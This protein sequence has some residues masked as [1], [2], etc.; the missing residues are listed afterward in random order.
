MILM[1]S[2]KNIM[3]ANVYIWGTNKFHYIVDKERG[4]ADLSTCDNTLTY[5][6]YPKRPRIV[7]F[8]CTPSKQDGNI[9]W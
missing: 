5:F 6:Q 4:E 1:T 2:I 3:K 9:R 8:A 7:V